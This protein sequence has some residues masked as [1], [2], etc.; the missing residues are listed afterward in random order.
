M[1]I[2][3]FTLTLAIL[4]VPGF[5]YKFPK[6]YSRLAV[7]AIHAFLF[8]VV[9]IIFRTYVFDRPIEGFSPSQALEDESAKIMNRLSVDQI[10]ALKDL[11]EAQHNG[12]A[13][14]I[15]TMSEDQ[16]EKMLLMQP[17]EIIKMIN[18]SI[19]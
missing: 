12:L 6:G 14:L 1:L 13:K 10:K 3:L 7:T 18:E 19:N 9:Y 15:S 16:I 5:L 4:F 11:T 8:T 2:F 17:D